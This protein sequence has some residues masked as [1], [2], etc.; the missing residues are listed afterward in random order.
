M[1]LQNFID[2]N[3]N[4]LDVFKS[5][6][7]KIK[8]FT[9]YNLLLIK[10]PYD[11][12]VNTENYERY[13]KGCIIDKDTKRIVMVPPVKAST[14]DDTN[15]DLNKC[16]LQE[17]FD[18][19]MINLFY[20]NDEWIHSTRS[21]IGL[22]NKWSN[23]KSFKEMFDECSKTYLEKGIEYELLN[24]NHTY[25]FVMQHVSNRNV[26]YINENINLLVEV[27]DR[28]TFL[29][30]NLDEYREL[31]HNGFLVI[32]DYNISDLDE[33]ISVI[34]SDTNSRKFSYKGFTVKS[35][36]MRKNYINDMFTVVKNLKNNSNN[37]LFDY[38]KHMINGTKD[39]YL[40]YFNEH[41]KIYKKYDSIYDIF[42]RDLYDT[43]VKCNIKHEMEKKDIPFQLKPLIYELHGKYLQTRQKINNNR[44]NEYIMSLE[45]DRLTFVMKYYL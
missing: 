9:P 42:K 8:T 11:K 4:A 23:K 40:Y 30:V 34:E 31:P 16:K 13:L 14:L 5:S 32:S 6:G 39:M 17:L 25:S 41:K 36:D 45:P 38:C 20:H 10:Y 15:I 12:N 33:F 37:P 35:N 21:D 44:V 29:P 28:D 26:S 43:Y 3:S 22:K 19:T 18:G 27:R 1:E 24:K 7:F 2:T